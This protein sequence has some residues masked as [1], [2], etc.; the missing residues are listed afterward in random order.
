MYNKMAVGVLTGYAVF[1]LGAFPFLAIGLINREFRGWRALMGA[2]A[3][4]AAAG[5]GYAVYAQWR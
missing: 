2:C 4:V 3:L 5:L 1:F